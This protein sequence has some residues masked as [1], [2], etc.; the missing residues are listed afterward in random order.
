MEQ[1]PER[2]RQIQ[3]TDVF[4]TFNPYFLLFFAASCIM[5]NVFIQSFML[6]GGFIQLSIA[7]G[8]LLGILLP[9]YLLTNRFPPG[10]V[11]QLRMHSL[12]VRQSILTIL[13][14]L[15]GVIV[16][17]YVSLFTQP[18]LPP[19]DAYVDFLLEMRPSDTASFMTTFMSLCVIV[20]LAEEI[21]FRGVIQRV[22]ARHM[23]SIVAVTLSAFFFA[24]MHLNP[25][26]LPG[27]VIFGLIVGFIFHRTG[28]LSYAILCHATL[29]TV[30][31][32]KLSL[33]ENPEADD[34]PY[35]LTQPWMFVVA[36]V[37]VVLLLRKLEREADTHR[38][39]PESVED[40]EDR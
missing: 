8:P 15:A 34:M 20:P 33:V 11:Y 6:M 26:L 18:F 4:D 3:Q 16:I 9:M 12:T 30:A 24:A 7:V 13:S 23:N 29:N 2:N 31:L 22:F 5:S 27:L 10:F 35:Y 36:I 39:P 28:N 14:T 40:S 37:L 38:L 32:I 21:A 17:D 19:S 25:P 1:T